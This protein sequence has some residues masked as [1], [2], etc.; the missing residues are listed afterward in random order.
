MT[1][2][3]LIDSLPFR[4]VHLEKQT[5]QDR[6]AEGGETPA[7]DVREETNFFAVF[8]HCIQCN[9]NLLKEKKKSFL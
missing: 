8:L 6:R 1:Q 3:A 7:P 9:K 4:P 5:E 2:A